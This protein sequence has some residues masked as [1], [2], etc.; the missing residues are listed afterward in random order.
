M[1]PTLSEAAVTELIQE[2]VNAKLLEGGFSDLARIVHSHPT[3]S[4]AIVESA[5]AAD[6]WL[7]HG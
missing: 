6:G 7:I 4:E 1:E 2:L 5:R 3:L